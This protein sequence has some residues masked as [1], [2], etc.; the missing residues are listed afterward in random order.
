MV[1]APCFD[2]HEMV[3]AY[4]DEL[5]QRAS[6]HAHYEMI[7][8]DGDLY[9]LY[10][11][12]Y[13]AIA[14]LLTPSF[15]P[16]LLTPL[17]RHEFFIATAPFPHPTKPEVMMAG[18]SNLHFMRGLTEPKAPSAGS[19]DDVVIISSGDEEADLLADMLLLFPENFKAL[20]KRYPVVTLTKTVKQY[21]DRRRG[22]EA[23]DEI[24]SKRDQEIFDRNAD[25]VAAELAT[26]GIQ[27]PEGF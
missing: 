5:L 27:V 4:H 18:L 21:C 19:S 23:I 8:L 10:S 12:L 25:A 7:C 15:N 6:K 20:K 9:G 11:E 16:G 26:L 22:Q 14:N 24:R 17:S 2:I 1:Q 13:E 3:S